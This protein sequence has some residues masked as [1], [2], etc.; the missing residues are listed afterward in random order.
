MSPPHVSLRVDALRSA[1]ARPAL[2]LIIL[3]CSALGALAYKLHTESIFACPAN[4]YGASQYLAYCQTTGYGDYDHGAFWFGLEPEA[5]RAAANAN[6]LFLGNSRMQ[7]AFS[8]EA[9]KRWSESSAALFYLLGFSYGENA[10]FEGPLLARLKPKARVYVINVDRFFDDGLVTAPTAAIRQGSSETQTGYDEKKR[11]QAFHKGICSA[12]PA[13]CGHQVAFF[14][15][16]DTG[17]WQLLG[18]EGFKAS[19]IADAPPDPGDEARW[20]RHAALGNEFVSRLP[21]NRQCVI[22]TLAPWD[23][24]NSA[25]ARAIAAALKMELVAPALPDLR[26]IDG[27]HLDHASSE[28]WASAFFE[29]AGPRIQRCLLD[30]RGTSR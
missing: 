6:V 13:V 9:I 18:S 10:Q 20:A 28:R 14:R 7:F 24:T 5:E 11:W 3:L 15:E 22:L 25:E 29:A 8:T 19:G 26:T 2:Y 23:A 30:A 16:R 12:L 21:V 17:A 27:D 1:V 4:G